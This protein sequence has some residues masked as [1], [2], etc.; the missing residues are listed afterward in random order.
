MKDSATRQKIL[1]ATIESIEKYGMAGCTIRTIAKEAGVTFSSILYYFESK[2][3]LI[4]TAMTL[5]FRHSME[6]LS[7]IWEKR[8]DDAAALSDILL[9]LFDGAVKY[10]GITRGSLNDLLMNGDADGL[11][12]SQ[13]NALLKGI[14]EELAQK[15]GLPLQT[16]SLRVAGAFSNVLWLGIAPRSFTACSG[17]DFSNA[18]QRQLMVRVLVDNLLRP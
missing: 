11:V 2:E 17:L 14:L 8:A 1:L 16:L 4:D 5:A 15:H 12:P 6:D 7:E 3:Q 9:F 13:I 10:P 18:Q